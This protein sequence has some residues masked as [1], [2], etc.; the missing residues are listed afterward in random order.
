MINP[1]ALLKIIAALTPIMGNQELGATMATEIQ[2]I[3]DAMR[4]SADALIRIDQRLAS[5]ELA[6][7]VPLAPAD[8]EILRLSGYALTDVPRAIELGATHNG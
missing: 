7:N 8:V 5:I 4:R 3:F 2:A 1:T 6:L